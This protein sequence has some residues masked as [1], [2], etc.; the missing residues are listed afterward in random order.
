MWVS[1]TML[2]QT[3]IAT[4]IPYFERFVRSFPTVHALAEAPLDSVLSHWS[5]LGYYRRARMLH[6]AARQVVEEHDGRLPEGVDGLRSL[7]GVGAYTAGAIASI[8]YGRAEA[9]VDGN[10]ARV[11]ARLM[12]IERDVSAGPGRALVWEIAASLVEKAVPVAPPGDWNQALMELGETVCVPRAPRCDECP[13][14]AFCRARALGLQAELPHT[15]PKR[16]APKVKRVAVVLAAAGHVL[17]ARRRATGLFGGLWETPMGTSAAK[18]AAALGVAEED[19]TE[20]GEVVHVL[21]HR[22]L[23]VRVLRGKLPRRR[24]WAPELPGPAYDA[25]EPVALEA[26]GHGPGAPGK[27]AHAT[28]LRKVLAVAVGKGRGQ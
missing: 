18:L 3:R 27:R 23:H 24:S 21:T 7:A 13:L 9:V 25:I 19:L 15:A 17:L 11:L 2:Q 26:L 6:A 28:L 12:A 16:A 14:R 20:V 1:E 4:V 22:R 5:G 10:V 8:A